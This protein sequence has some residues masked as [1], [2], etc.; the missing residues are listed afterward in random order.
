[1]PATHVAGSCGRHIPAGTGLRRPAGRSAGTARRV[2]GVSRLA[3]APVGSAGYI[4]SVSSVQFIFA[5]ISACLGAAGVAWAV[6]SFRKSSP[7]VTA[8]VGQGYVDENGVLVVYLIDGRSKVLRVADPWG[9]RRQPVK[10]RSNKKVRMTAATAPESE[11]YSA[12]PV[13]VVFVR[14]IGR[15]PATVQRC[16]YAADLEVTG[17]SFEP[18]PASSPWGDLLPKR[19]DPSEEIVLLHEKIEMRSFLNTVLKDHG[20]VETAWWIVLELGN[21]KEVRAEPSIVTTA[22]MTDEE[23]ERT[24]EGR[25]GSR[26]ERI[27]IPAPQRRAGPPRRRLRL[28][29]RVI[30][31]KR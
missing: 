27:E 24:S 9:R 18:Q 11:A 5:I 21:G 26:L 10:K 3:S 14:N 31:G 8:E 1:M 22:D 20:V 28:I 19:L 23:S 13:N 2:V 17:F 4:E 12:I 25:R 30:G 16:R 6:I 29:G 15:A 7:D